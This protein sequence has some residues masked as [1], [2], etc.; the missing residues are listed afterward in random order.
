MRGQIVV[1]VH[2]TSRPVR[3]AVESV[4]NEP[5]F[6]VVL[7]AHGVDPHDLDLPSDSRIHVVE[8]KEA[9]GR[10][11]FAFNRGFEVAT[12]E[13]VGVLGSDDWYQPGALSRMLSRALRDDADGVLAP[14]RREGEQQNTGI[15][16]TVRRKNLEPTRDRLFWRSSPLGIF[17]RG[18]LGVGEFGFDEQVGAGVDQ[19]NGALLWAGGHRISY[20]PDDPPYIVGGSPGDHASELDGRLANHASGWEV[21]WHDSRIQSL[22]LPTR[23]ALANRMLTV[24]VFSVVL[25]RASSGTLDQADLEWVSRL[26]QT[27]SEV[28]PGMERSLSIGH[29]RIFR[30]LVKA[31]ARQLDEALSRATFVQNRLPCHPSALFSPS[32]WLRAT[33]AARMSRVR[34]WFEKGER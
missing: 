20:Y 29:C 22:S 8:V 11:G 5:E 34:G 31:D 24:N 21:L 15:P 10:P 17:K 16:A 30:A 9:C 6:G 7:V 33:A 14:Q 18:L 26:L 3:R 4:L 25:P 2:S 19:L 27:M 13:W 12:A 1:P 23:R 28:A 32:F